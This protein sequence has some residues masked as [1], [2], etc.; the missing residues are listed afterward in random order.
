MKKDKRSLEF[1]KSIVRDGDEI[2]IG[3]YGKGC[4]NRNGL[5]KYMEEIWNSFGNKF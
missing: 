5:F 1:W 2:G 3:R 4:Y